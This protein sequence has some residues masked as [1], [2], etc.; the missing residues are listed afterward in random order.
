MR[1]G[2]FNGIFALLS[3]EKSWHIC[4]KWQLAKSHPLSKFAS[5]FQSPGETDLV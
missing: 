1:S 4:L 2:H 5:S 3:R